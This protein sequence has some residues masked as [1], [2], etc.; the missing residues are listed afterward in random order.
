MARNI[1]S[2]LDVTDGLDFSPEQGITEIA[3]DKLIPYSRHSFK[4][5]DGE[6]L[7]DM[8][9]SIAKNGVITPII[10][11]TA[12]NG[13]YE[14]LA[15]HNRA[16]AAEKAGINKIPAVVKANLSDEEAEIYVVETN[17]MLFRYRNNISYAEK[18]IIP[19]F[20]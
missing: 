8:I 17:L 10:V 3:L 14:I 5:Y 18:H 20:A 6:R 4:L 12:D 13:K 19:K 9:Q 15:G 7:D 2:K 16:Y 1:T 11:R